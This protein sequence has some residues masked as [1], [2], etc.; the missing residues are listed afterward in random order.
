MTLN[1]LLFRISLVWCS[2]LVG[3]MLYM[4]LAD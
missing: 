3:A 2:A 1:I 4:A